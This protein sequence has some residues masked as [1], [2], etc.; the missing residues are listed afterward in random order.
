M[1]I[2]DYR[3]SAC[4]QKFELLVLGSIVPACKHCGSTALERQLALTAPQGTSRATIA[5]GRRAA[6]REGHFSHY[7]RAE[8]SRVK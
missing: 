2:H 7:S 4:G 3:C 5:A 6:A 1:P 8:R